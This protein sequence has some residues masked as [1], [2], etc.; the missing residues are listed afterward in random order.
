MYS[1][2]YVSVPVKNVKW[3]SYPKSST[4]QKPLHF[5][6]PHLIH[7]TQYSVYTIIYT[8]V[9]SHLVVSTNRF[10]P[11]NSAIYLI[12]SYFSRFEIFAISLKLKC[13]YYHLKDLILIQ[14]MLH[15]LKI[16]VVSAHPLP[17]L[18]RYFAFETKFWIVTV[19]LHYN[20][21]MA[22]NFGFE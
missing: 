14:Q 13:K 19:I 3:G 11:T 10:W 15:F 6:P 9:H 17:F 21:F 2:K 8:V 5:R 12:P 7:Y 1:N 4:F 16:C 20:R 22:V 18:Q